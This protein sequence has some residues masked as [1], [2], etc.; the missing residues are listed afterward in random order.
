VNNT[1][2]YNLYKHSNLTEAIVKGTKTNG[3]RIKFKNFWRRFHLIRIY[4]L[5]DI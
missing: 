5:E 3:R 2:H 4:G 1:K